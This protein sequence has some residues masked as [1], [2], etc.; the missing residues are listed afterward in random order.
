MRKSD[1]PCFPADLE[2][3]EGIRQIDPLNDPRWGR[4]IEKHPS[5]S[6][7]HS[8]EWLQA[9]QLT[10]GYRPVVL[11]TAR[12]GEELSD[13]VVVCRVDSMLTGPRLV[14]LPFSDHCEP[15]VQDPS[16]L[17]RIARTLEH[18]VHA[19]HL[20]YAEIRPVTAKLSASSHFLESSSFW[21]HTLDLRPSVED[22]FRSFHK[23]CVQRKIRRSVRERIVCTAGARPELLQEFYR[24]LMITRRR[25]RLAPQSLAWFEN[26]LECFGEDLTI[27]VASKD[28]MAIA[29]IITIRRGDNLIFKYGC[30]DP[31]Y[32]QLG[33]IQAVFWSAIRDAK[34]LGL[35]SFDL[36]R[37]D[38][39]QPG[40]IAFK[41]RWGTTR[42]M[43]R[44]WRYAAIEPS[45][46]QRMWTS[47][48]AKRTISRMPD[49]LLAK[50]GE[51][52]YRHLG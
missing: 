6:L 50:A 52:L 2:S 8:S 10:Y 33:G 43:L 4:F 36:G 31:A 51:L 32:W 48:V 3:R 37:S 19:L 18:W 9:L 20:R 46:F 38:C 5:A 45:A 1:L 40:L 27:R 22:L 12:S 11:T 49:L 41:D 14:S 29:S 39:D 21:L 17:D 25:H 34:L 42:S 13:G 26:L 24:L 7:F 35:R 44:Y 28:G 47:D 16:D 30:S 23:N 15:L